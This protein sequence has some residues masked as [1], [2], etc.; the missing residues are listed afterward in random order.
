MT[1]NDFVAEFIDGYIA[2]DLDTMS[3]SARAEG[4][5][6][7]DVGYPMV[8]TTLAGME[9]LGSLLLPKR[10]PFTTSN[11]K[12]R[13]LRFW[14]D[15]LAK[16]FPVYG[17]FGELFYTLLRSGLAHTY[18]AKHGVYVT[19]DSGMPLRYDAENQQVIIDSNIFAKD[20]LSAYRK[21]VLPLLSNVEDAADPSASSMQAHLDQMMSLYE[22]SSESEFRNLKPSQE[23]LDNASRA[24]RLVIVLE[25]SPIAGLSGPVGDLPTKPFTTNSGLP[26]PNP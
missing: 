17:G 15:Y 12:S 6:H 20:F 21:N 10:T 13:F 22:L 24:P 11:G 18:T 19:K 1:V 14:D 7:G 3:K 23:S 4:L 2:S 16:D 5:K 9:L 25:A 8:L 26:T